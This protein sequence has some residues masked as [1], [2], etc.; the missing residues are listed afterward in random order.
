MEHY[1]AYQERCHKEVY[2][3]LKEMRMIPEAV[4]Q[5]IM[6]LLQHDFLGFV[7]TLFLFHENAIYWVDT[8]SPGDQ[9]RVIRN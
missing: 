1:C 4:E 6:H 7:S 9:K 8:A 3:K 5:I 2:Q